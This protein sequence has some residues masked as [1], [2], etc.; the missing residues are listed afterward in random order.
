MQCAYEFEIW[1]GES[2]FIAQ[3]FDMPV[4]ITQGDDLRDACLSAIDVLRELALDYLFAGTE[5]P[6]STFGNAPQHGGTVMIVATDVSLDDVPKVS[7]AEAARMLGVSRGRVTH[8]ISAG[9]LDGW[10]DG[11]N[12]FVTLASVNARLADDPKPG[13]PKG[14]AKHMNSVQ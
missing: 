13:R 2:Q 8:M 4:A 7:A 10:R 14:S 12:T 1:K 3:A 11:R 6:A 5:M 9:L